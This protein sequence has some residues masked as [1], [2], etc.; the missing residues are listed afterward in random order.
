M[1]AVQIRLSKRTWEYLK[2]LSIKEE[3]SMN[4]IINELVEKHEAENKDR[5]V[6]KSG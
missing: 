6:L 4:H 1:K 3:R 2:I 5:F